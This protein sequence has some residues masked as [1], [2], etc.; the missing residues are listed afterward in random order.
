MKLYRVKHANLLSSEYAVADNQHEA[1]KKVAYH[2]GELSIP[3]A[4]MTVEFIGEP[5]I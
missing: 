2:F 1:A 4:D 3:P 5:L